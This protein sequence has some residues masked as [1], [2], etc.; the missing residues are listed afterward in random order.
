[1]APQ[2][3]EKMQAW[4]VTFTPILINAARHIAFLVEGAGKR[5]ALRR[6]L[7]GPD[8]PEVLPAQLIRPVDGQLHWLVDAAAAAIIQQAF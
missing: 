5:E 3:V 8:Q 2:Y 6:V 4:R 1:V 7:E